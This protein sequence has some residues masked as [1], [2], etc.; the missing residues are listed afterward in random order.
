[1]NDVVD[2]TEWPDQMSEIREA[3]DQETMARRMKAQQAQVQP[4]PLVAAMGK[5]LTEA[6]SR[7]VSLQAAIIER[8]RRIAELEAR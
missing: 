3:H 1:M 7:E 8:D 6:L 2:H 4:D 5:M